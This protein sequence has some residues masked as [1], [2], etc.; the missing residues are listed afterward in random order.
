MAL[1]PPHRERGV[2]QAGRILHLHGAWCML[3]V[4]CRRYI[5]LLV[6]LA[7]WRVVGVQVQ[8]IGCDDGV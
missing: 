5:P 4:Q 2:E 1:G 7:T 3:H 6:L 8:D